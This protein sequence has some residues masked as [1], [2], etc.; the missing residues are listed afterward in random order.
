MAIRNL[1]VI[2]MDD[3][4]GGLNTKAGP[5][6]LADNEYSIG[7]NIYL[8]EKGIA[9]RKGYT[10]YNGSA[11]ISTANAGLGIYEAPFVAASKIVGVAGS[12]IKTKGTN[13]WSDITGS[14]SLTS[15]KPVQFCMQN[16]VLVGVNGTDAAWYYT[17]SSTAITLSGANIPTTPAVCESFHGRL[18]LGDGRALYWSNYMGSWTTF[19]ATDI[20]Y[21]EDTITGLKICGDGNE[22]VLVIFLRNGGIYSCQF[23]TS[24][25]G[26]AGGA[27]CFTFNRVSEKHGCASQFSVQECVLDN[28]T[29]V[30]IWADWDGLKA[31]IPAAN[32]VGIDIVKLTE[33]IQPDWDNLNIAKLTDSVGVFFKRRRWYLLF[34]TDGSDSTHNKVIVFDTRYWKP[35]AFWDWAV[36]TA[37][38]VKISSVGSLVGCDYSGYWNQ[39]DI[40]ESDNG[41]AISGYIYTKSYNGS[42]GYPMPFTKKR[43]KSVGMEYS[44][45]GAYPIDITAF[46]D[47]QSQSLTT[48]TYNPGGAQI[49]VDFQL[50][51]SSFAIDAQLAMHAQRVF[52]IGKNIQL[53]I[54]NGN[55]DQPFRIHRVQV[56]FQPIKTGIF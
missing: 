38:I 6:A 37:G 29:I 45:L 56:A 11:R 25:G 48:L 24:I 28:G 42:V 4:S 36:A 15:G 33:N 22:A 52:G 54:G 2:T 49:G 23:N 55:I 41:T 20:Q 8:W 47:D 51:V 44:L 34:C 1:R 13:T 12:L 30:L 3:F 27:L 9:K 16:N 18:F 32:T 40:E 35:I 43:F 39:Y 5:G 10:R 19:S 21:F 50:D 26:E 31:A 14:V 7:Q 53:K 46:F 17:G